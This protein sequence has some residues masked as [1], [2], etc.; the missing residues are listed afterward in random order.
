MS[1]SFQHISGGN[2]RNADGL[3]ILG[4]DSLSTCCSLS[5]L[6]MLTI[7]RDQVHL[8]YGFFQKKHG[9]ANLV[10]TI[11]LPFHLFPLE[12]GAQLAPVRLSE[13]SV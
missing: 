2:E 5:N 1:L 9:S 8:A 4:I 11:Q 13:L 7:L 6:V 10:I 3:G 12:E